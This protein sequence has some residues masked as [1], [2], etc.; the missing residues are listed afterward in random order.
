[1]LPTLTGRPISVC[2][3]AQL[4]AC[5]GKLFS[6]DRSTG[7][8]VHAASFLRVRKIV[9]DTELLRRPRLLRLIL[10]HEIFH[11][12][13]VRL[14][15]PKRK[16]FADILDRELRN[17]AR[18]ETGESS[19]LYKE[20]VLQRRGSG[21]CG[22]RLWRDYVCEAFCDTAAWLYADV[23]TDPTAG[24]LPQ[25]WRNRRERWFRAASETMCRC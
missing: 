22:S 12:V 16:E 5:R 9:L 20:R 7:R 10:L 19:G 2:D 13:W 24:E 4:T 11:F 17:G 8:P 3:A 1:M 21:E 23:R 18:G 6:G 14:G 15:N 25:R